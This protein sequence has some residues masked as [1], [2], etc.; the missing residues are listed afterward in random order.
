MCLQQESA[1]NQM[2]MADQQGQNIK[3]VRKELIDLGVFRIQGHQMAELPTRV[4]PKSIKKQWATMS[5]V[6]MPKLP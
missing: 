2:R 4:S 6:K 5:E 1:Q 3:V